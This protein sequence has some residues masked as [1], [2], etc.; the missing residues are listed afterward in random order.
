MGS[1]LQVHHKERT[2]TAPSV[3]QLVATTL[4]APRA[5]KEWVAVQCQRSLTGGSPTN[6]DEDIN[7]CW[8][9]TVWILD[10]DVTITG[11]STQLLPRVIV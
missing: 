10:G 3:T 11:G 1:S 5:S 2:F 7:R 6:L 8:Q 4:C 9:L